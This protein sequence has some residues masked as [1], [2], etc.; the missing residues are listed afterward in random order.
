VVCAGPA[1]NTHTE[2]QLRN[3]IMLSLPYSVTEINRDR[4]VIS[5]AVYY[6]MIMWFAD[7]RVGIKAKIHYTGFP[8]SY[9]YSKSATS[10]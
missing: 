1:P 7:L 3:I 6:T 4:A 2:K 10:P 9:P 8:V 5:G